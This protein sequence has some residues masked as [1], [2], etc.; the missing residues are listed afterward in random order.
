MQI[1]RNRVLLQEVKKIAHRILTV[2]LVCVMMALTGC[3]AVKNA[4]VNRLKEIK[5]TSFKVDRIVPQG[6]KSLDASFYVGI[7][8][9]TIKLELSNVRVELFHGE[10]LLGTFT[11]DPFTID[12]HTERIYLLSGTAALSSSSSLLSVLSAF[13]G[14]T[15][16]DLLI[17]VSATGKGVGIK[18]N[19]SKSMTLAEL[20]ELVKN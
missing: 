12:G 7:N 19:V 5:V 9:P 3:S 11:L 6:L 2:T 14:S 16:D 20:M 1:V 18:R 13:G 10:S 17:V 8:N 15:R 4:A